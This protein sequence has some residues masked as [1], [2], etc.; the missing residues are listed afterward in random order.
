MKR[1]KEILSHYNVTS[2]RLLRN[3]I[4]TEYDELKNG[5]KV[6]YFEGTVQDRLEALK[7]EARLLDKAEGLADLRI[8]N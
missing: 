4:K 2:R 7:E 8:G 1:F 5:I 3:A 6:G